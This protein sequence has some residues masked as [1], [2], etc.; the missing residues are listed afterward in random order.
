MSTRFVLAVVLAFCF[1]N[2]FAEQ[3]AAAAEQNARRTEAEAR[4]FSLEWNHPATDRAVEL[5]LESFD[6][7]S[8][9]GNFGKAVFCLRKTGQLK[10]LLGEKYEAE[11][12]FK[13]ALA[14]SNKHKIVDEKIKI[15]SALSLLASDEG[16]INESE[17]YL[18]EALNSKTQTTDPSAH[19]AALASAG[20]FHLYR[21]NPALAVEYFEQSLAEWQ[22][23]AELEG[24]ANTLLLAGYAFIEQENFGAG[25]KK[26]QAALEKWREAGNLRGQALTFTGLGL[27]HLLTNEK[28]KALDFYKQAE[29]MFPPDLDYFEKAVLSNG[30][31]AIY[32]DYGE[33]ELSLDYRQKALELYGKSGNLY[34]QLATLPS[35]AVLSSLTGEKEK[36]LDYAKQATQL[37]ED[38]NAPY[39][40]AI[41]RKELGNFYLEAE[42]FP[43]ALGNYQK[44]LAHFEQT[45]FRREVALIKNK[46]GELFLLQ[47]RRDKAR[48]LFDSALEIHRRVENRL[49]EAQTLFNLARLETLENNPEKALTYNRASLDLTETLSTDVVNSNLKRTYLSNVF[50]RYDLYINILMNLQKQKPDG[51]FALTALQAAEKSRARSILEN[52]SLSEANFV[53]DADAETVES[54]KQ[55]RVSLNLK[56]DKLTDLLSR[57]AEK[58]EIDK[59][60][61]EI[62]QL[63]HELEEIRVKLK[64]ASPIYSAV[65]N[66]PPFDI[67]EFQN[68]VLD[69]E[70]LLFEFSFGE[71]E[72]YL[73]TVGKNEFDFYVLPP[74]EQIETRI[75]K[76][77]ELLAER[78]LRE[79]ET[80]EDY[81]TR[82][83]RAETVYRQEARLLSRDLFAQ[84]SSKIAGKRLIIVPDG[85][86]HYFPVAALPLPGSESDEPLLLSNETLYEPS[87]Q[88]LLLLNKIRH[89]NFED[90]KHLL[91]F[92]D[93]V[94]T[95]EDA[96][97]QTGNH[98]DETPKTE[99]TGSFRF[100]ESLTGLARL[101]ASE[102]EGQAV[103]KIVGTAETRLLSGFSATRENALDPG[104]SKY[105]IIHFATHGIVNEERPELSGI[106]L[107]AFNPRGERLEQI[108]RLHDIYGM[109]LNA[110]LVVLSACDTAVGKQI[111]GEGLLSLNNAF[112]SVGAKSV[113]SS[114]WKVEDNA[115][116]ELMKNFYEAMA[117]DRLTPSKALQKAQIKL[118]QDA[119]FQSPFYWA[120]FTV[121]GDY[122]NV[123]DVSGNFD[124]WLYLLP[125][126]VILLIAFAGFWLIRRRNSK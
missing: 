46:L 75:K 53:K 36:A 101:A 10:I 92:A 45:G 6:A 2:A 63:E 65:K 62:R 126:P 27:A 64:Q 111:K 7:W 79:G 28:Q 41:I 47:N 80:V 117:N 57:N 19:A 95:A 67:R 33:R 81:Q 35:L 8:G 89:Q 114:L 66:P 85:K 15:L 74:R 32:E 93:P 112:L 12:V 123:P 11:K 39:Y 26:M 90:T 50:E 58:A 52:L 5:Y 38:L 121:Q 9:L 77:R 73:W 125:V 115:T 120:A 82:A 116:L 34:G 43:N 24:E 16:R 119:R 48:S 109:S 4:R 54:E 88:T 13:K 44:A 61:K 94:F 1:V 86:L 18:S 96:R 3:N 72:S 108:V 100:A 98:Q 124:R 31:G 99:Q 59:L 70:S 60:E 103:T 87:A 118:R 37:A 51:N 84:I 102:I 21:K 20:E 22:K 106:V 71:R 49:G 40:L 14:L 91:V 76:L 113:M 78:E 104:I 17:N 105:K 107:S 30:I 68:R 69:E 122:R 110:D 29:R 42:D 56:S 97:L 83:A 55:I 23:T 25:I